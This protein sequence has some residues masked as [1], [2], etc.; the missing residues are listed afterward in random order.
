MKSTDNKEIMFNF[1]NK[2][3]M[4]N[5]SS[6]TRKVRYF[7]YALLA[8]VLLFGYPA[9]Y[10]ISSETVEITIKDK[11]RITTGSGENISSKFIVY[12]E[13][14]VFENTDSWLFFKFNSADYQNKLEVGKTY[15]VKVA[16]WRIPFLSVYRNVVSGL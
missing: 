7:L 15:E 14:E 1:K 6:I 4:K 8:A 11:E 3:D 16:G 12:T 13:N 2:F 10:Y 5:K 9:A